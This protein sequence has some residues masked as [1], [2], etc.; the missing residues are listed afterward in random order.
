MPSQPIQDGFAKSNFDLRVAILTSCLRL[1][2]FLCFAGWAWAHLYW[3]PSYSSLLWSDA[4]FEWFQ[5]R[6]YS[7][8]DFAGTGANDGLVQQAIRW[9]GWL[10]VAGAVLSL[11]ARRKSWI[12]LG[13]LSCSS[14]VMLGV[15]IAKYVK[16]EFELPMLIEHGGQIL[17]PLLLVL[18][19][20]IGAP[21]RRWIART[22]F[23]FL[24]RITIDCRRCYLPL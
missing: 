10:F 7:W 19:L 23:H 14:L 12:Q 4:T 8:E 2:T 3:E 17:C 9:I 15:A 21:F 18:A 11:T 16:A 5:N 22:S 1:G 20:S 24:H 13:L 6:G